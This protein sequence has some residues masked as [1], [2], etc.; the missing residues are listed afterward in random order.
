[1]TSSKN[2]ETVVFG[3]I[4]TNIGSAYNASTGYFT[5]P[6][7]GIFAFA[8]TVKT[9][10][11]K[12]FDSELVVNGNPKL[13]NGA[14]SLTGKSWE[15]SGCT[16]VLQLQSGQKVWIRKY[17]SLGNYLHDPWCSFSGWQI[18]WYV[19]IVCS[20]NAN[21][22][23]SFYCSGYLL[24]V[25]H[26]LHM[27]RSLVTSPN[28]RFA[29][30]NVSL[31]TPGLWSNTMRAYYP[32]NQVLRAEVNITVISRLYGSSTVTYGSSIISARSKSYDINVT[33]ASY[34]R[35]K[36]PTRSA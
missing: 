3:K 30:T 36:W 27:Y 11:G 25:P 22:Q 28:I 17:G 29:R 8:W 31:T 2:S 7:N 32:Q 26:A 35:S 14:N 16:G 21:S 13:Y 33:S 4:I 6:S 24:H 12:W 10:P 20:I 34:A 1:M 23:N 9:A 18:Q 19:S 5:A 15:S